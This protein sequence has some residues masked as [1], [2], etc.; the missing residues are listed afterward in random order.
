MRRRGL[1]QEPRMPLRPA[2]GTSWQAGAPPSASSTPATLPVSSGGS[3]GHVTRFAS[4]RQNLAVVAHEDITGRKLAEKALRKS[5]LLI[6]GIVQ[7]IPARVFWKDQDLVYLGCNQ[8]FAQDAGLADSKDIIGRDDYQLGWRDQAELYRRDDREVIAMGRPKLLIEEPQTTPEG[9]E[10]TILTSK[11]P[12]RNSEGDIVGVIGTYI[13][14]TERIRAEKKA[15]EGEERNRR[16][17]ESSTDAII[18]RSSD[19]EE[20]LYANPAA[21]QLFRANCAEEIVGRSYLDLVHPD[22]RAGTIER[23]QEQGRGLWTA[24]PREHRILT[25]SGEV[26]EMSSPPECRC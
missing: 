16:L 18:I 11:A 20:I 5:Q 19:N 10:I 21:I 22:D 3:R 4:G 13:D 14:I 1:T 26:C 23:V 25:L 2:S 17:V 15:T 24:P 12:L 9:K 6:E 7:T 8:A